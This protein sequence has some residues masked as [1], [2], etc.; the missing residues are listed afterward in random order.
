MSQNG[1]AAFFLPR[2][3]E[4]AATPT[5]TVMTFNLQAPA[6]D[7]VASLLEIITA[8]D[9]DVIALQELSAAAADRFAEVLAEPCPYQALHPQ[10]YP[11]A[12]QGVLSRYP[13]VEDAYWR[14]DEG[15][16]ALGHQRVALEFSGAKVVFYN[17]H[18]MPPY[19]PEP[20]FNIEQHS[21]AL[22][23]V[24][25]RA[26]GETAPVVILGDFNLTDHFHEYRRLVEHFNDA[27]KRVG[28]I[29]FGFTYPHDKWPGVPPLIRLDYVF[30]SPAWTGLSAH[31]GSGSGSSDHL[32]LLAQLAL[33]GGEAP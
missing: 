28:D 4:A 10:D 23:D 3:Q 19:A 31:V 22:G 16:E 12:G 15:E 6:E 1:M 25:A 7:E 27:Y 21:Q 29:G 33:E 14:Y 17:T 26:L 11:N 30:Y 32:P 9:A 24:L 8:A 18:P 2:G 13:I 20:G 5:L